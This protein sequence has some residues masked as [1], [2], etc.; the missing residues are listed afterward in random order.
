MSTSS[1]EAVAQARRWYA[2]RISAMVLAVCVLMHLAGMIYAVRGGLS[3]AEILSR[4]RGSIGLATFYSVFVLACAVHVPPGLM[5]IA[6][7]W[8]RWP[9]RRS[10]WLGRLFGLVILVA[11]LRAVYAVAGA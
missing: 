7:E 10:L 8:W 1:V 9:A 2:Q 4:T 3:A 11:G 5:N 6:T